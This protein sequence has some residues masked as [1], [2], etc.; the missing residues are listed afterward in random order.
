[1]DGVTDLGLFIVAGLILNVTPGPD[2]L[3]IAGRSATQGRKAGI[4]AA[5][6]IGTGCLVHVLAASFGL[7][8]ILL[9]S[10]ML[11]TVVKYIGAAYLFYLGITTLLSLRKNEPQVPQGSEISLGSIFRQ[12][13][14]INVLNPKV[15]LFFLALLPQFVS[16]AAEFAAGAFLFLGLV[17]AINGTVV[18]ILFAL[19][20]AG[21][22][23]KI[24]ATEYVHR[25]LKSLAGALF[26]VFGIRLAFVS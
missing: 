4:V 1:M 6:G 24:Q 19:F 23:K 3:Y 14:L 25:F 8:V 7:S 21:L 20:A 9:S 16:P 10:S 15:A 11:F 5:I 26:L 22:S 18:N 17:F 2:L 12:A 13:V